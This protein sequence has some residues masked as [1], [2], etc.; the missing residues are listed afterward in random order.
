[1]LFYSLIYILHVCLG[2]LDVNQDSMLP[3][4]LFQTDDVQFE[5]QERD[6]TSIEQSAALFLLT[7][8]ERYQL[9]QAAMD[10]AIRQVRNMFS[11]G[12]ED[13]QRSV[14][15]VHVDIDPFEHLET[16]YFQTKYYTEHFGLVV[17]YF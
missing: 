17:R 8:K 14:D 2:N 6:K 4:T 9:T 16:E 7:L 10:F 13:I 5:T 11:I 1:M 3:I 15:A 12:I